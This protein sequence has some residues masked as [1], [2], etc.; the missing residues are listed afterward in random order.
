MKKY[1][2][3]QIVALNETFK[4]LA[5]LAEELGFV[6]VCQNGQ[7]ALAA[8]IMVDIDT[9]GLDQALENNSGLICTH[10]RLSNAIVILEDLIRTCSPQAI[11]AAKA[12]IADA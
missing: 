4:T 10:K 11:E 2:K 7:V 6:P 5:I 3:K 9:F 1:T 8:D 12:E